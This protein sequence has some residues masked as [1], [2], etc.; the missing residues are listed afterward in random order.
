MR[1]SELKAVCDKLSKK[2]RE[3]QSLIGELESL[4]NEPD[5]PAKNGDGKAIEIS[6]D[7][8]PRSSTT[9]KFKG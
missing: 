7:M 6:A 5:E 4:V 2:S 8:H 1:T 9:Q 3:V